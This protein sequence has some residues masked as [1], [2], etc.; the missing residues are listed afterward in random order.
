[1]LPDR[2]RWRPFSHFGWFGRRRGKHS[3]SLL[4]SPLPNCCK[5]SHELRIMKHQVF[6]PKCMLHM[7]AHT[8]RV[9]Q[10]RTLSQQPV[11]AIHSS[12]YGDLSKHSHWQLTDVVQEGPVQTFGWEW[13]DTIRRLWPPRLFHCSLMCL[14]LLSS[15]FLVTNNNQTG[16]LPSVVI[17][18][19]VALYM[20]VVTCSLVPA[21]HEDTSI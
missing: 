9:F 7:L 15:P 16:P 8:H 2:N 19:A 4:H 12:C 3:N 1:M 13:N 10:V 6:D 17:K 14:V 21:Q 20:T 11:P 18:R 5:L